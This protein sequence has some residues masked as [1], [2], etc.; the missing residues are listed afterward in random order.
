MP[1]R[2]T[3]TKYSNCLDLVHH[4][5]QRLAATNRHPEVAGRLFETQHLDPPHGVYGLNVEDIA[6]GKSLAKSVCCYGYRFL[7]KSAGE[8]YLSA[9]VH[10][11]R[12]GYHNIMLNVGPFVGATA[13]ALRHLESHS[14]VKF[15]TYEARLLRG[16]FRAYFLAIWLKSNIESEDMIYPLPNGAPYPFQAEQLYSL[17]EFRENLQVLLRERRATG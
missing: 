10:P 16:Y 1:L 5:V 6:S 13:H 8:A 3:K 15:A 9:E 14:K 17:A 12:Q 2:F 4:R 7:V 11:H